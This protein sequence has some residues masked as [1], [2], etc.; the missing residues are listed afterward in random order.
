LATRDDDAELVFTFIDDLVG[1]QQANRA[2]FEA[3]SDEFYAYPEMVC[4][5]DALLEVLNQLLERGKRAGSVRR[6]VGATDVLTLVKGVCM[7][8]FALDGSPDV[9]LRHIELIRAAI[10][11]P[12]FSRPLRGTSPPVPSHDPPG[13]AR[14]TAAH[15]AAA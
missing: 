8:Q 3:I 14:A 4:V 11:T 2:L 5:Y 13:N 7:S 10:T 1:R 15:Q 6:E 12:D 9:V